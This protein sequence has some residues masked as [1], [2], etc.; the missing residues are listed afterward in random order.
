MCSEIIGFFVKVS[1]GVVFV[2][3]SLSRSGFKR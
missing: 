3:R 2:S 1:E